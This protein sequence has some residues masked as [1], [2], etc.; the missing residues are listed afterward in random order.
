V[1]HRFEVVV[2]RRVVLALGSEF[3]PE[4]A[5]R[6]V[7]ATE[8]TQ[9]L[10]VWPR[11]PCEKKVGPGI[12][13]TAAP[14]VG[15]AGVTWANGHTEVAFADD[16]E[17]M[18]AHV[19]VVERDPPRNLSHACLVELELPESQFQQQRNEGALGDQDASWPR[20]DAVYE[21]EQSLEFDLLV[22]RGATVKLVSPEKAE[23]PRLGG[24]LRLTPEDLAC[25]TNRDLKYLPGLTPSRNV[26]MHVC[27]DSARP[28]RCF[29]GIFAPTLSEA[30]ACFGGLNAAE[31]E[32]NRASLEQLLSEQLSVVQ[33]SGV[34]AAGGLL[35][36]VRADVSFV[37]GRSLSLAVQWA[38]QRMQEIRRREG[39]IVC[40]LCSQLPTAELQGHAPSFLVDQRQL[41]HLTALREVPICRVPFP[42]SDSDFPALD[43]TRWCGRRFV[44]KVPQLFEWWKNRL[45]LC[46]IAGLTICNAPEKPVAAVPAALDTL[47]SRQLDRDRQLRWASPTCRPDLGETSLM[48]TDTQD[49]SLQIIDWL[50]QGKDLSAGNGDGQVNNPGTYRSVCIE[51]SLRTKICIAAIQH[52]RYLSDMEGGELSKKL[53]RKV[54]GADKG[55]PMRNVDHCSEAES[56]RMVGK[57]S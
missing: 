3:I 22:R 43:W 38:E 5:R 55:E 16:L 51:V 35:P 42:G 10:Q 29:I 50:L 40:V 24:R 26:Y 33:S 56:H 34:E 36:A 28:S 52:A 25:V 7:R 18:S 15:L 19:S 12:V 2:K 9:G 31:G 14:E 49:E 39:G 21:A 45:A 23:D 13:K 17:R 1:L 8:L 11:E 44:K 30:W 53:I 27:F 48:L 4:E 54:P 32:S 47:Y 20:V 57:K 6:V 46:R 37:N 41:R